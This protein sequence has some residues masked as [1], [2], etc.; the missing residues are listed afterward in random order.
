MK[1]TF[2]SSLGRTNYAL[3]V[4]DSPALSAEIHRHNS[5]G[6]T[7]VYFPQDLLRQYVTAWVKSAAVRAVSAIMGQ[8]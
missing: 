5:D 1:T 8:L 6:E 2:L 3:V 7:V 4:P